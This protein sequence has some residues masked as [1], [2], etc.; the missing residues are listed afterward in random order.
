MERTTDIAFRGWPI[1]LQTGVWRGASWCS[2]GNSAE[3]L[4]RLYMPVNGWLNTRM[5]T[6]SRMHL[7]IRS[8]RG[9]LSRAFSQ[10]LMLRC[11]APT[12]KWT[13]SCILGVQFGSTPDDRRC[14]SFLSRNPVCIHPSCLRARLDPL[15]LFP[16]LYPSMCFFRNPCIGWQALSLKCHH[17][18][19]EICKINGTL[20]N[21]PTKW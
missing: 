7:L 13:G 19:E 17:I 15:S 5:S 4:L 18:N 1:T 21:G 9:W 11:K 3:C 20:T 14:C 2:W 6:L 16:K 8:A 10:A 12:W